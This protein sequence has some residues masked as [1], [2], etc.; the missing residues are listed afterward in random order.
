MTLIHAGQAVAL[1]AALLSGPLAAASAASGVTADAPEQLRAKFSASLVARHSGKCLDVSGVRLDNGANVYQ[2]NCIA[3]QSNQ[4]W[5]FT[6]V[7]AGYYTL[8]ATHSGKCLDVAGASTAN[9]ANVFQWTCV[10]GRRN[11]QWRLVQK[12]NGYFTVVA[13]H[14]GKC[15]DVTDAGTAEGVN[16]YQ[17]ACVNGRRNQE[18]RLA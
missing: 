15:L 6:A 10:D 17:W 9:G 3:G 18:W 1:A 13:R 14:S 16:V 4:E 7:D 12:D 11:Q 5:N 2:W 8:R